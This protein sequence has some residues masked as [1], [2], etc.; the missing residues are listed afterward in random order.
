VVTNRFTASIANRMD[1]MGPVDTTS[2]AE[3]TIVYDSP[4]NWY[5]Y[6]GGFY[7][8][9][10]NGI[11]WSSATNIYGNGMAGV[12]WNP[13]VG[14]GTKVVTATTTNYYVFFSDRVVNGV[15]ALSGSVYGLSS[16]NPA[17]PFTN[18]T[19]LISATNLING[20]YA[21]VRAFSKTPSNCVMFAETSIG[22]SQYGNYPTNYM[23]WACSRFSATN[24]LG[25]WT[26]EQNLVPSMAPR[27]PLNAYTGFG[28]DPAEPVAVINDNNGLPVKDASGAYWGV[29]FPDYVG[30][31]SSIF[32]THSLDLTNWYAYQPLFISTNFAIPKG[33]PVFNSPGYCKQ[34]ADC[35]MY[36][37]EGKVW[38]YFTRIL[39]PTNGITSCTY[40]MRFNGTIDDLTAAFVPTVPQSPA[41]PCSQVTISGAITPSALTNEVLNWFPVDAQVSSYQR[42]LSP[43][44]RAFIVYD[45][46]FGGNDTLSLWYYE[47]NSNIREFRSTFAATSLVDLSNPSGTY[48]NVNGTGTATV[49]LVKANTPETGTFRNSKSPNFI[50][51]A[52]AFYI[53]NDSAT[54]PLWVSTGSGWNQMIPASPTVD[55]P[56]SSVTLNQGAHFTNSAI[57]QLGYSDA[58]H[59]YIDNAIIVPT[60]GCALGFP[61]PN[62]YGHLTTTL[63]LT[64]LTQTN[65]GFS[66][67]TS[68]WT[69]Y[70][71]AGR[72]N[73]SFSGG[74]FTVTNG[75]TGP[76]FQTVG[77]PITWPDDTSIREIVETIPSGAVPVYL[78]KVTCTMSN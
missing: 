63:N 20:G 57:S 34:L 69:Y 70:N 4:G 77:V 36:Y 27:Q 24:M 22:G 37:L 73:A 43:D 32:I 1:D 12:S 71:N 75:V 23:G 2:I 76:C 47:T 31:T 65:G 72:M 8:Y 48:T 54:Y 7:T 15:P 14:S 74:H 35:S 45:A 49:T 44:N 30:N 13:S 67:V 19:L 9:S 51:P 53:P 21:N 41:L 64:F 18:L 11:N 6:K 28:A 62:G 39:E 26:L 29:S 25:P 3:G 55:I 61:I 16:T 46:Q 33:N 40:L 5:F 59:F 66:V 17:G 68:Y 60:N 50:A 52:G 38:I 42:W 78:I 58:A 56:L 10:T